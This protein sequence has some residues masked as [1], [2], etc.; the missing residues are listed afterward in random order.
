MEK[1]FYHEIQAKGSPSAKRG[2]PRLCEAGGV[3]KG[4]QEPFDFSPKKN[5][6]SF[7]AEFF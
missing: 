4:T 2:W 3:W 7:I 6:H 1:I 5:Y